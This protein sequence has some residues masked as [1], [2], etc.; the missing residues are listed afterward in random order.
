[1]DHSEEEFE[2]LYWFYQN[3]DFGPAD[4]DVRYFLDQRYE[5]ETGRLI[6][7]SYR[8]EEYDEE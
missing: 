6:P 3:A 7:P 5:K 4:G 8:H 1:M 2:Y